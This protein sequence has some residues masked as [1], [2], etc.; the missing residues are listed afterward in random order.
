[1]VRFAGYSVRCPPVPT[2]AP[3]SPRHVDPSAALARQLAARYAWIAALGRDGGGTPARQATTSC[4]IGA[5]RARR[6][7]LS[8][9]ALV[10]AACP[11]REDAYPFC[12]TAVRRGAAAHSPFCRGS[13]S[14]RSQPPLNPVKDQPGICGR[15]AGCGWW[16]FHRCLSCPPV[17]RLRARGCPGRVGGGSTRIDVRG[18]KVKRKSWSHKK[19]NIETFF[20]RNMMLKESI[21]ESTMRACS[22]VDYGESE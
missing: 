6:Q 5:K 16:Q 11:T 8:P 18:R 1:M 12:I 14:R 21:K 19:G 7:A 20:K 22:S 9:A 13:R 4:S 10:Q 3:A 2:W 17:C 15:L